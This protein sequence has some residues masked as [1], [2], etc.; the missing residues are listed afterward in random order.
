M[1]STGPL[2]RIRSPHHMQRHSPSTAPPQRI[3]DEPG[4]VDRDA[5]FEER[6]PA[7]P[8]PSSLSLPSGLLCRLAVRG[9]EPACQ[10]DGHELHRAPGLEGAEK[11]R[12][13]P[14]VPCPR[15]SE[16]VYIPIS[17]RTCRSGWSDHG[18]ERVARQRPLVTMGERRRR[19]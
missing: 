19:S 14:L 16:S 15:K 2:A 1:R 9:A 13:Q 18:R 11:R 6:R 10:L 12:A 8:G 17:R 3:H 5:G 7:E 4:K